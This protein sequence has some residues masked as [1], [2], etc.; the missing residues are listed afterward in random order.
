MLKKALDLDSPWVYIDIQKP[1]GSGASACLFQPNIGFWINP[2]GFSLTPWT[3][4]S[5]NAALDP[6][7]SNIHL[8]LTCLAFG[9]FGSVD[10]VLSLPGREGRSER[11]KFMGRGPGPSL[12]CWQGTPNHRYPAFQQFGKAS[13][14][15]GQLQVSHNLDL[16]RSS[17]H[18]TWKK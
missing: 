14:R 3:E 12:P 7:R 1:R 16:R 5:N 17:I 10:R 2:K 9:E 13:D 18:F 4:S 11:E 6:G 8:S 15:K